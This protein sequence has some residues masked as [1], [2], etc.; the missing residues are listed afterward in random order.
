MGLA[1]IE[2]II[3]IMFNGKVGLNPHPSTNECPEYDTK[4]SDAG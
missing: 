1:K 2:L 4:Q 3:L